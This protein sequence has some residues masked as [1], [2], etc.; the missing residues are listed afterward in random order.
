MGPGIKVDVAEVA[1]RL[2][3]GIS[4]PVERGPG[5][6]PRPFFVVSLSLR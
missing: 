6:D 2:T 1:R 5:R 4:A 3:L